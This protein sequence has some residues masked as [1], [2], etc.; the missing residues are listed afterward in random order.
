M[1]TKEHILVVGDLL[2]QVIAN[3]E[4]RAE[5]HDASKLQPPEKEMRNSGLYGVTYGSAEY[6]RLLEGLGPV[7]E[8]HYRHNS[9]HPEHFD[10]GINGMSLLD[11]IEMLADWAAA[12]QRHADGDLMVSMEINRQRFGLS[13]Q[14]IGVLYNTIREMEWGD[15]DERRIGEIRRTSSWQV[16]AES[17]GALS[18]A[19]LV[20]QAALPRQMA[21]RSRG[22]TMGEDGTLA[23]H[24]L[25]PGRW[26]S[27]GPRS[28]DSRPCSTGR[29]CGH[30]PG[31]GGAGC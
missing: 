10:D 27:S 29:P 17:G 2:R 18:E 15:L 6:F 4:R 12:V 26:A 3:I 21:A 16:R 8:H 13:D 5:M 24:A 31:V 20:R 30:C 1:G 7:L 14:L 25:A 11:L 28:C 22:K 23:R 19:H 9:H